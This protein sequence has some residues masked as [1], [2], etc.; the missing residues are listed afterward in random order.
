MISRCFLLGVDAAAA[1]THPLLTLTTDEVS[2]RLTVI[3]QFTQFVRARA[4]LADVDAR[5]G[6]GRGCRLRGCRRHL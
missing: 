3:A 6:L 5:F 4:T 1:L 2:G